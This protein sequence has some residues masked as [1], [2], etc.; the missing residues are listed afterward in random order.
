MSQ[1]SARPQAAKK[2]TN[3]Q[4]GLLAVLGVP[5]LIASMATS[6]A[7]AGLAAGLGLLGLATGGLGALLGALAASAQ[8]GENPQSS[9]AEPVYAPVQEPNPNRLLR[10]LIQ[11]F[12]ARK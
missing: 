8:H 2:R 5:L 7:E 3:I 1:W 9:V 10:Y 4:A 6:R 11:L 12:S